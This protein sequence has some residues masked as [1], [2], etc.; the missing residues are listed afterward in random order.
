MS[1]KKLA[2]TGVEISLS[3]NGFQNLPR[4]VYENNFTFI[5]EGNHYYCPS[6]LASLLSP[7]IC[8]LQKKDPTI[9]RSSQLMRFTSQKRP[10]S[11]STSLEIE[12][13]PNSRARISLFEITNSNSNGFWKCSSQTIINWIDRFDQN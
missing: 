6:F 5:V 11:Q 2:E 9:Q 8:N 7:R 1:N 10:K 3:A 4:N 12:T 13:A